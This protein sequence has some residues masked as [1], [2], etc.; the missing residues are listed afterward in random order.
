VRDIAPGVFGSDPRSLTNVGGTL[1]FSAQ[2]GTHGRELWRSNGT[3]VGTTLVLDINAGPLG[4]DPYSLT[5]VNGVLFFS[6]NDGIHGRELW[7]SNGASAG[8]SMVG[9]INA[10]AKSCYPRYLANVQGTLF[11]QATDVAHGAEPWIVVVPA[12]R[13]TPTMARNA[14]IDA[15]LAVEPGAGAAVPSQ[16]V[17]AP[18]EQR[19]AIV[20]A[21]TPLLLR[22]FSSD[23]APTKGA[24]RIGTSRPS[25][26]RRSS[27]VV[28]VDDMAVVIDGGERRV[29]FVERLS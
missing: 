27:L 9:D 20:A 26:L 2:D 12:A 6:A 19:P 23:D 8:T 3:A 21:S 29:R 25:A 1:F 16:S 17:A 13:T 28:T 7:A 22:A 4:S 24:S 15:V 11:F 18:G 5:N 10:G 14:A